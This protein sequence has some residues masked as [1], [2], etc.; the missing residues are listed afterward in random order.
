MKCKYIKGFPG[1]KAI[2]FT[3]LILFAL[4]SASFPQSRVVLVLSKAKARKVVPRGFYFE[5]QSAPTQYRN[6]FVARKGAK[7]N[8]IVGLVDTSGYSSD[9]AAK[10][11]GFLITDSK[12]WIGGKALPTGA[13]GFGFTNDGKLNVHD[14]GGRTILTAATR[15]DNGLRRPRP[16]MLKL[17]DDGLRFYKGRTYLVISF[18]G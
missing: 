18:D 2:G 6:S 16:L 10:Y 3:L 8:V 11:E 17:S 7:R 5:G 15:K 13:Y 9:I 14:V 12:V 1:P 4:T